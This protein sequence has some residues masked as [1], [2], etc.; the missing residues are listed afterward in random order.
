MF[1]LFGFYS[2][3]AF[4]GAF[5]L[6]AIEKDIIFAIVKNK[7][8]GFQARASKQAPKLPTGIQELRSR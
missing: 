3:S 2:V 1:H 8:R 4:L 7:V 5:F 6:E